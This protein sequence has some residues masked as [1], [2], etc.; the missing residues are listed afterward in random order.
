MYGWARKIPGLLY[1]TARGGILRDIAEVQELPRH[2]LSID[3]LGFSRIMERS[4]SA[5]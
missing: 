1:D 5:T 4:L 2:T 3:C